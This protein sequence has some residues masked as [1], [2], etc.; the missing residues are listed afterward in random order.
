MSYI[1]YKKYYSSLH[2]TVQDLSQEHDYLENKLLKLRTARVKAN[3]CV[4][5]EGNIE[6]LEITYGDTELRLQAVNSLL[7][8]AGIQLPI[9]LDQASIQLRE[10]AS[11]M[12]DATVEQTDFVPS[13]R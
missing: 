4:G 6:M 10:A 2:L 13:G 1:D 3:S 11:A 9:E 5:Y 12:L 7:L 8:A